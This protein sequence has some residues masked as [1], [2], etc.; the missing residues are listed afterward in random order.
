MYVLFGKNGM[1]VI[2]LNLNLPISSVN[3]LS[4]VLLKNGYDLIGYIQDGE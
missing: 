4:N 3:I 2:K 1:D